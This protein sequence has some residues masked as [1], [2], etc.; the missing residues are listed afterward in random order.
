MSIQLTHIALTVKNLE[1]S[2]VFYQEVA[3]LKT[4]YRR[5]GETTPDQVA[6][7]ADRVDNPPFVIVLIGPITPPVEGPGSLTGGSHIGISVPDR[8]SVDDRARIGRERGC[9][10]LEPTYVDAVVGY[11]CLLRDP[12]GN[13]VEFSYGQSLQ[14]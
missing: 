14:V 12:D 7:I 13:G 9:L 5:V 3:G 4:V 6:W 8:E 1:T 2:L 10:M 11:I